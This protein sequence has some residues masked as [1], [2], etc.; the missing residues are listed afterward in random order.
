MRLALECPTELLANIQPLADFDWILAHLVLS[1]D[2]YANFYTKSTRYKVLDNSVHELREPIELKELKE[3]ATRVNPDLIVAPDY[4][5][6]HFSTIDALDKAVVVFG[7][8]KIIPVV[9]GHEHRY[10][11][12]CFD[13]ILKMGFDKVAIPAKY[14]TDLSLMAQKRKDVV[15]SLISKAPIGFR[16]HL[17]GM[18]TLDELCYA[19]KFWIESIDTGCPVLYGLKGIKFGVDELPAKLV[20][21]MNQLRMDE[22]DYNDLSLVYY[23]IAFVRKLINERS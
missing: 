7:K 13:Y 1:D 5:N 12:E 19:D 4:L 6:D 18:T 14:A 16:F 21:T 3:A 15:T 22:Y 11:L 17:L 10:I 8:E 20:A 9:Q 2:D 23:N